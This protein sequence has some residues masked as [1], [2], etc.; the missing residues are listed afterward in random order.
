SAS[1]AAAVAAHMRMRGYAPGE[2]VGV[3]DSREDLDVAG[4]VGR[5]FVV[6]N[7]LEED[8]GLGAEMA[9]VAN[10]EATEGTQGE[11]FYEAVVRPLDLR[12]GS[13]HGLQPA[14]RPAR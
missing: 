12:E 11:G 3:G 6:A 5:F 2:C 10:A 14:L 9:R 13:P 7:A 1:K 8:S 4:C